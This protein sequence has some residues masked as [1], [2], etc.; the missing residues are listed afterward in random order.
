MKKWTQALFG[1]CEE[2]LSDEV[3]APIA[4]L[5]AETLWCRI[6]EGTTPLLVDVRT[7]SEYEREHIAG[8]RL[9]PLPVL[10]GRSDELPRE[11]L[12]VFVCRAGTLSQ[13]ACEQL[14]ENGFARLANLRGG[15]RAW[16]QAGLPYVVTG[17]NSTSSE[18]ATSAGSAAAASPAGSQQRATQ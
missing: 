18:R 13:V 9:L 17:C 2:Q 5:D 11:Q 15:M 1:R 16:K 7:A 10:L 4:Q 3:E 8:A 6:G 14:A 12:L